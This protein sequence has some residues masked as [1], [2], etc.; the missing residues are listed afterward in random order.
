MLP[1]ALRTS[2]LLSV[3]FLLLL[4]FVTSD[5]LKGH[6]N[7]WCGESDGSLAV[8]GSIFLPYRIL[9]AAL[10]ICRLS[11]GCAH[12]SP[13]SQWKLSSQLLGTGQAACWCW[14][15]CPNKT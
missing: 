14:P 11:R 8:R 3:V 10:E 9:S 12:S 4:L 13:L 6:E 1:L 7:V 5:T 2:D 15:L